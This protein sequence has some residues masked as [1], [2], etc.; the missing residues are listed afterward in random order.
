M[1]AANR[2]IKN[3]M[4]LY[5]K[6]IITVFASLYSTRLV[7]EALG[8]ND[9]GIFTLVAGIM[10]LMNFINGAM[11][12][13]TQRFMSV[14][15]GKGDLQ[16]ELSIFNIGLVIHAAAGIILFIS[17]IASGPYLFD[18]VLTIAPDRL[19]T[20]K[21]IFDFMAFS[22]FLSV[23]S[24]PYE[25][26][27]NANEDMLFVAILG[28]IGSLLHLAVA[29]TITHYFGDRLALYGLLE[30]LVTLFGVVVKI[31]YSHRKYAEV[32]IKIFKFFNK[33]HFLNMISFVGYNFLGIS[34]QMITSYGQSIVLNIFF[35]TVVNAAQGV[36]N[37]VSGQ[38]NAFASTMLKALNPML[39]KSEG[40]GNRQLLLATSFAGSKFSFFLLVLFY[41]PV[42][43][44]MEMIFN[45]WL[46][47]VPQYT[48]IFTK[49]LLLRNLIEQLYLTLASTIF[50]VG[51]I[52][53]FQI[54]NAVWNIFPLPASYVLFKLGYPPAVIYFVF[55]IYSIVQGGIYIYYAKKECGMEVKGYFDHVVVRSLI[56]FIIIFSVETLLS[57]LFDNDWERLSAVILSNL[58]VFALSVWYFGLTQIEKNYIVVLVE[59]IKNR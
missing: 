9:F 41:I 21:L 24:V 8:V 26:V 49:L 13:A 31:I 43:L 1:K 4:F 56:P 10:S 47:E 55:I 5:A 15:K 11:S 50:A 36:V 58:V 33:Q 25:S 20:A 29:I 19:D 3:T 51:K 35:G 7:L 30:A 22:M 48:F 54:V 16:E 32:K 2:V 28:I 6:M 37:Q 46:V 42:L 53:N 34:T 45:L 39:M 38:L 40:A 18:S 12:T 14:S 52:R 57:S 44:E 17:M 59:K 23:A 27:I